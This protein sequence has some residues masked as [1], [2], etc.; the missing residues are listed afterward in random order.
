MDP[1]ACPSQGCARYYFESDGRYGQGLPV[2]NPAASLYNY[3][4]YEARVYYYSG[5]GETWDAFP[6]YGYQGSTK[7]Y[8]NLN[9]TYNGKA[10]QKM[11]IP[12]Q[13]LS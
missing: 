1:T 11:I 3:T 12:G 8:G 13:G 10:S 7:W 5:W 6:Y 2:K 4:D 9:G